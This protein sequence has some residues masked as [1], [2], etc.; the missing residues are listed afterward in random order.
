MP[1]E[2]D[3]I[4]ILTDAGADSSAARL[5]ALGGGGGLTEGATNTHPGQG[6]ACR[7]F[8]FGNFYIELLWVSDAAEA[9]SD[10][11]RP[12]YLFERWSGRGDGRT[13]PF[14]IALRPGRGANAAPAPLPFET[15]PYRPPYLPASSSEGNCIHVAASSHLVTEPLVFYIPF[16]A[17]PDSQPPPSARRQ[18]L[19]H[20]AGL[21]EIAPLTLT[22]PHAD[23]HS[24]ALGFLATSGLLNLRT[25]PAHL[26]E[27]GFDH[28]PRGRATDLRPDL[29][30]VLRW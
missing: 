26:L 14:G 27:L 30:L 17:R 3:H 22:T 13:S 12:T 5:A 23:P 21:R 16:A 8:F 20:A 29:P 19:D 15:R 7:R 24:D 25:G 6:T 1:F 2:L 9:Q 11:V 18:P 10:L 28:E 4:F